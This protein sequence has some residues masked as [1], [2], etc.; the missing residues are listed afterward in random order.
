ME[1]TTQVTTSKIRDAISTKQAQN[2]LL[3]KNH[4]LTVPSLKRGYLRSMRNTSF[5]PI[6]TFLK[7]I[8]VH[9]FMFKL[10]SIGI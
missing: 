3:S 5:F 2:S 10:F 8:R 6:L 7:K 4:Q 9:I 1:G